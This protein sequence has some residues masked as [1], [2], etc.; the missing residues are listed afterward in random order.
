MLRPYSSRHS[1]LAPCPGA[2]NAALDTELETWEDP[3]AM[4][5]PGHQHPHQYTSLPG[6]DA[7]VGHSRP[8]RPGPGRPGPGWLVRE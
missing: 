7:D 6:A 5:V 1:S 8:G 4:G 3:K 2:A